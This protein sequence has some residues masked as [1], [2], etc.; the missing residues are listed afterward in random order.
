MNDDESSSMRSTEISGGDFSIP[1]EIDAIGPAVDKVIQVITRA[2]CVPANQSDIEIAL[3][4]ALANAVIHGNGQ[5]ARKRVHILCRLEPGQRLL[6][7]V[8]DEGPGFDPVKVPDPT[9]PENVESDHGRG[10]LLMKAFMDEVQFAA[11]GTEVHM[12]KRLG[13]I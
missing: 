9:A 10:I 1:S 2:G 13:E 4:E 5:D 12:C 11:G 7:V 8:R 6:I 3:F